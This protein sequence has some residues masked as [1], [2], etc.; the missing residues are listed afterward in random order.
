M[1]SPDSQDSMPT[2][3]SLAEMVERRIEIERAELLADP[4]RPGLAV[5]SGRSPEPYVPRTPDLHSRQ[6]ILDL[7]RRGLHGG[8]YQT[9]ADD[10]DVSPS[11]DGRRRYRRRTPY[12]RRAAAVPPAEARDLDDK[13]AQV[14]AEVSGSHKAS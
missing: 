9:H 13:L 7:R 2:L 8:P 4:T 11:V 14:L 3:S 12:E 5:L 1:K 10:R 6:A